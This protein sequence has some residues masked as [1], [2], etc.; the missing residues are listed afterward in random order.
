MHFYEKMIEGKQRKLKPKPTFKNDFQT[1][2]SLF[3]IM[4]DAFTWA[5]F[6]LKKK[7]RAVAPK[8]H[9]HTVI[10]ADTDLQ[11]VQCT[12]MVFSVF[13]SDSHNE[14]L[15]CSSRPLGGCASVKYNRI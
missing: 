12:L 1:I 11:P 13:Y 10:C 3:P 4:I 14:R 6:D 5:K 7:M 2:V 15:W 8:L 9:L